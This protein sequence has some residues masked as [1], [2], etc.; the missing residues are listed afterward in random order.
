MAARI[1]AVAVPGSASDTENDASVLN[2]VVGIVEH[3]ADGTNPGLYHLADHLLQPSWLDYLD[4]IVQESD[5]LTPCRQD[6]P[7]IQG[8]MVKIPFNPST[9]TL[10]SDLSPFR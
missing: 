7:I 2:C 5:N 1:E 10:G 4:V 8:R 9:R 3:G 6:R